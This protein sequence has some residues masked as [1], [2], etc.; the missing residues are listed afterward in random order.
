[1]AGV[2]ITSDVR[3]AERELRGLLAG[4]DLVCEG[5]PSAALLDQ[6]ERICR[7]AFLSCDYVDLAQRAPATL[8]SY[9][10]IRGAERCEGIRVWPQLGVHQRS[11]EAGRAFLLAL[12]RLGLPEFQDMVHRENARRY[13][14]PILIHGG[15]PADRAHQLVQRLELELERGLTGGAEAARRLADEPY[16]LGKP[17]ARLLRYASDFAAEFLDALIDHITGETP[18]NRSRSIPR[19]LRDAIDAGA[20]T[21]RPTL[22]RVRP[23]RVEFDPWVGYGPEIH[24]PDAGVEWVVHLDVGRSVVLQPGDSV[25]ADPCDRLTVQS[26][27]RRHILWN[28]PVLWFDDAGRLL[29]PDVDLPPIVTVVTPAGWTLRAGID[30]PVD[31]VDE[32]QALSG[33]WSH[34]HSRTIDV[35]GAES[36][37]AVPPSGSPDRPRVRTVSR[38]S[39]PRLL[40]PRIEGVSTPDG[41]DVFSS[42]PT[43]E[44][45]RVD[46]VVS[47]T[48]A[49]PG[50]P[51]RTWPWDLEDIGGRL[52]LSDLLGDGPIGGRLDVRDGDGRRHGF[53]LA[54]VPGLTVDGLT[55]PLAPRSEA[56]AVVRADPQVLRGAMSTVDIPPLVDHVDIDIEGVPGGVRIFVPRV[57]WGLRSGRPDRLE[58]APD[59]IE[60]DID[61]LL[62]D[63]VRLVARCG[64][65]SGVE[66]SLHVDGRQ[67]QVGRRIQTR[68]GGR[69]H[70]CSIPIAPFA[71]TLRHHRDAA[72]ELRLLVEGV[73]MLA[74]VCGRRASRVPATR[75][76]TPSQPARHRRADDTWSSVEWLHGAAQTRSAL[77]ELDDRLARSLAEPVHAR[78]RGLTPVEQIVTFIHE[79]GEASRRWAAMP[80]PGDAPGREAAARWGSGGAEWA[81][82]EA[83]ADEVWRLQGIRYREFAGRR[84]DDGLLH[85]SR[86]ARSA[87]GLLPKGRTNDVELWTFGRVPPTE[88]LAGWRC[89]E[90]VKPCMPHRRSPSGVD[91]LP[92]SLAYQVL[93]LAGGRDDAGTAVAEAAALVPA[94]LLE[95]VAWLLEVAR[96][97]QAFRPPSLAPAEDFDEEPDGVDC[98]HGRPSESTSEESVV[99]P[100]RRL[101]GCAVEVVGRDLRVVPPGPVLPSVFRLWSTGSLPRAHAA[102]HAYSDGTI[103]QAELPADLEGEVLLTA[104]DQRSLGFEPTG[105]VPLHLPWG[106]HQQKPTA[107][108]RGHDLAE[109]ER[110]RRL[111]LIE[112]I[113]CATERREPALAAVEELFDDEHQAVGA[114]ARY[115]RTCT[116][117]RRLDRIGIAVL[118]TATIFS[119]LPLATSDEARLRRSAPALWASLA[120]RDAAR[121][122]YQRWP[123]PPTFSRGQL[124]YDDVVTFGEAQFARCE[125]GVAGLT[126]VR[127]DISARNVHGSRV[128]ETVRRL[129][130]RTDSHFVDLVVTTYCAVTFETVT[131]EAV[132]LLLDA[133][134][135]R[136]ISTTRAVLVGTTLAFAALGY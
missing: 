94:T 116:D 57:R 109:I 6:A 77:D 69:R 73:S 51:S 2:V 33:T 82:F 17:V 55:E 67:L 31:I 89:T 3:N 134:H 92:A 120:P 63:D 19:H 34:H 110:L 11:Q 22:R 118:P 4:V 122:R 47:V 128:S 46:G 101:D 106:E 129:D 5:D 9:V 83:V 39:D 36:V 24:C 131:P 50:E 80:V 32:G 59:V 114:L 97:G 123:H 90:W 113:A 88:R 68:A 20:A 126:T 25:E 93:A 49:A 48:F 95:L 18:A 136:P 35:T 26:G 96:K 87:L 71:D 130:R 121:W 111:A 112:T 16:G 115:T 14:A 28:H 103:L 61:E 41:G 10:A 76:W 133:H 1:M 56:T 74:V 84:V 70:Q 29:P 52:D 54:V 125:D 58:L 15:I 117:G 38:R 127:Y 8:A 60:A 30:S 85:W 42:A 104:A 78:L 100:L 79:L 64:R 66:L 75:R 72:I 102:V 27:G 37:T 108:V 135:H 53:E 86:R 98:D 91:L 7:P 13:V 21:R 12:R 132:R 124:A 45:P 40:G 23:P 43:V 105:A 99:P 65:E 107:R 119:H 62:A 81:A 44:L